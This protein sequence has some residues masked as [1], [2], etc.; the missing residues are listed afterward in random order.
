[1]APKS[2]DN[3][4]KL[5]SARE[6]GHKC[7]VCYFTHIYYLQYVWKSNP[8]FISLPPLIKPSQAFAVS[9]MPAAFFKEF[10]LC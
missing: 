8:P 6:K 7:K 4:H 1:M 5:K 9:K 10:K 3:T 2:C